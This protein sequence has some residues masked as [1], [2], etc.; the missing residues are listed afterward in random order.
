[1]RID[2]KWNAQRVFQAIG[3][4]GYR[5]ASAIMDIV[6]NSVSALATEVVVHFEMESFEDERGTSVRLGAIYIIDNGKG[7]DESDIDNALTLG[8]PDTHYSEGTLSKFGMGMKSASSSL[9]KRLEVISKVENGSAL[10]A[11]LDQ[12]DFFTLGYG[13]DLNSAECE[14]LLPFNTHLSDD[15]KCG[16]IIKISKI[17]DSLPKIAEVIKELNSKVGITF[18]YALNGQGLAGQRISI[19][20]QGNEV[21]PID[22][23]FE[24]ECQS[25][26]DENHW[27]GTSVNWITRPQAIQLD[28]S[29]SLTAEVAMTQLPHPPS[30]ANSKPE[31]T[32]NSWRRQYLI[33]AGNYGF[34]IYR[35]GRLISWADSL[36]M[37]TQDQDLYSFRGRF[38]ITS[39]ADDVLNIDVTK[40]RIHLSEVAYDQLLPLVSEA[41]KK[42]VAAWRNAGAI[43]KAKLSQSPHED[44][45][46]ALD[47]FMKVDAT[48][49]SIEEQ[50]AAPAV[51]EALTNRRKEA[52]SS[53]PTNEAETENLQKKGLRVQY[54]DTLPNNQLWERAHDPSCGLIVRV[55]QSHRMFQQVINSLLG[56]AQLV[57]VLDTF[58]LCLAKG[59]YVTIYKSTIDSK[60]VE[61]VLDEYRERVGGELSE[62][63]R[64]INPQ[65]LINGD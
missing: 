24:N 39:D 22:P 45:N 51:K 48:E 16:T 49:E 31:Q 54:V 64:S 47:E 55:N 7:M 15:F 2:G 50:M 26:L 10:K 17:Y 59:E 27:D 12:D 25:D 63:L 19:K 14:E 13:Y 57:K 32:Q 36:G 35:N 33:E 58:F 56:N 42:S 44:I 11:T 3:R 53:K 60:I 52:V 1:M 30:L 65:S 41:K 4:I 38:N 8:S 5:P 23:L 34:Y 18:F 28:T 43:L 46:S 21:L 61:S 37:V 40:S 29:G 9:G 20:I 62:I 6:D